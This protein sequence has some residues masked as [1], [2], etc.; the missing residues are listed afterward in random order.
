[1]KMSGLP[2]HTASCRDPH[3]CAPARAA[4][5]RT[6]SQCQTHRAAVASTLSHDAAPASTNC[7]A[8]TVK[9]LNRTRKSLNNA[10]ACTVTVPAYVVPPWPGTV[11]FWPQNLKHSSLTHSTSYVEVWWTFDKYFS[12]HRVN[13]PKNCCFQQVYT[14]VTSTSDLLTPNRDNFNL[15]PIMHRW[16]KFGENV[17][18]SLQDIV[19]TMFWEAHKDAR[20]KKKPS[21]ALNGKPI[22]KPRSVTCHMGSHSGSLYLSVTPKFYTKQ[23][24]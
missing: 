8:N 23:P 9:K 12:R 15:C 4:P 16:R 19:L 6:S 22:T 14:T 20:M 11:T 7:S 24:V 2:C 17:S 18:N 1:M 10:S 3:T 21:L 5:H 13:K